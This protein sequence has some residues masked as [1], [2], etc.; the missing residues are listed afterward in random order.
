MDPG[1]VNET[2]NPTALLNQFND[3]PANGTWTLFVADLSSDGEPTV[4]VNWGL[5]I[6]TVPEPEPLLLVV[7]GAFLLWRFRQIRLR[8][9]GRE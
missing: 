5:Q 3:R 8:N 2:V 4:L 7:S 6:T 1:S 9:S